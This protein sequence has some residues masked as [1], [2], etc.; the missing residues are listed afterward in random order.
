MMH[1]DF[2]PLVVIGELDGQLMVYTLLP[3]EEIL[4]VLE[5]AAEAIS[6]AQYDESTLTLQ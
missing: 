3:N 4:Q 5:D 1:D 2:V 6:D